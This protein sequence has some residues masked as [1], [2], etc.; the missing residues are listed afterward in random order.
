MTRL[1]SLV[2]PLSRDRETGWAF[3]VAGAAGYL[4]F[5]IWGHLHH[6]LW[7]DEM[8]CWS[9]SRLADGFWDL[10]T[11]DRVYDG[12]PPLWYGYLRVWSRVT[13][14]AWG[15]HAATIAAM[16][17]AALFFLRFAP[18]PRPLKL[19]LLAS[20]LL[21][22]EYGVLSRPYTLTWALV[23][24][25]CSLFH[26][27][28][29]RF[30][31]LSVLLA[32]LALTTVFG[33]MMTCG[34][35]LMLVPLGMSV[36]FPAR[37]SRFPSLKVRPRFL[38]GAAIVAASFAFFVYSTVPPDP[39]PYT[40]AW[41]FAALHDP[42][43]A[44]ALRK[45]VYALLPVRRFSDPGYWSDQSLGLFWDQHPTFLVLVG[46]SLALAMPLALLPG[47]FEAAGLSV[48]LISMSAFLLVRYGFSMRHI[49]NLFIFFVGACWIRR[50]SA[51]RRKHLLSTVLLTVIGLV[52]LESF[53]AAASEEKTYVFSGGLEMAA[54]IEKAGLQ[55]LPLVA[56]PDAYISTVAGYLDRPFISAE[57]EE[58]NE[59]VVFHG[60]LHGFSAERL[61]KRAAAEVQ[62]KQRPVLV[63]SNR[64]LPRPNGGRQLSFL[65]RT[66]GGNGESFWL[67]RMQ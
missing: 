46:A 58:I 42:G 47:W 1:R 41:K 15:L 65:W 67:Y 10:V 51:P 30:I 14:R 5:L 28:R 29:P 24:A 3:A 44:G 4:T 26:P 32:L 6:E 59:T 19:L 12:H 37:S 16:S 23:V 9:V 54:R 7:R 56:G 34:F 60:S 49:G 39:N 31:W 25:F 38:L 22:Y 2:R 45:L 18:F 11:G 66:A 43:I 33:A 27:L 40:P 62:A 53:L 13:R 50:L 57:T 21:G 64:P 17:V 52:Q 55:D 35:F 48:G 36:G 8:H 61:L 20:Y 63:L